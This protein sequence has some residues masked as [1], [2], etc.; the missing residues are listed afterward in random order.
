MEALGL[1]WGVFQH[2]RAGTR[3]EVMRKDHWGY[4]A[5]EASKYASKKYQAQVP[6]NYRNVGRW[7][8]YHK[9]QRA[10]KYWVNLPLE[11]PEDI[12]DLIVRPLEAASNTLPPGCF[13]F[14][15]K[16]ER[17]FKAARQGEPYG[18]ITVWGQ[19]AVDAALGV[20]V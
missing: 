2:V 9:Y 10:A 14:K 18:Y 20:I 19:P 5:K 1:D 16:L 11:K 13:R 6:K 4:A 8:G 7:W 12:E 15:Q 17:F 3:L